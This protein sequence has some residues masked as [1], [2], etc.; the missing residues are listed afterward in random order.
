MSENPSARPRTG[1]RRPLFWILLGFSLRD[2]TAKHGGEYYASA[3]GEV[4]VV[5]KMKEV[6]A[7]I[8]GEGNGGVIFPDSHYGR[9]ALMGIALFLTYFSKKND[10]M[11]EIKASLPQYEMAKSKI[12]LTPGINVDSL[13]KAMHSQYKDKE[14]CN[15]IDGL[16]IDFE[17]A[18]VHMRKSNTEPII[19]VYSEANTKEKAESIA[20]RFVKELGALSEPNP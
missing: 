20:D 3:V 15:T 11:S 6:N 17:D 16:K 14:D 19:R 1:R 12:Q 4:N 9:D 8:G 10:T 5:S 2:I 18:W 13:V 7:I